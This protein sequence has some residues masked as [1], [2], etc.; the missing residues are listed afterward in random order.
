MEDEVTSC[1]HC[2]GEIGEGELL[3]LGAKKIPGT[4]L[5]EELCLGCF[6]KEG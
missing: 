5:Y 3:M 4:D 6:E 2:G 1:A